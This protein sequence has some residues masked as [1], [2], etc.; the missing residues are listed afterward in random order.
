MRQV[1]TYT[2]I[3][4]RR[5]VF[6]IAWCLIRKAKL[7]LSDTL[8]ATY[9]WHSAAHLPR[10]VWE[11]RRGMKSVGDESVWNRHLRLESARRKRSP[12]HFSQEE[13]LLPLSLLK[14]LVLQPTGAEQRPRE[15]SQTCLPGSTGRSGAASLCDTGSAIR[16]NSL[17]W[18]HCW[19]TPAPLEPRGRL[20]LWG[21]LN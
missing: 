3:L 18:C 21:L 16:R 1:R 6:K 15:V 19:V 8:Y 13:E 17:H 2:F 7:L 4:L 11:Y 9:K 12:A 20:T 10:R 14:V 5:K